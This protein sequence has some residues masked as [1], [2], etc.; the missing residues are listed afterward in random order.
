[1]DYTIAGVEGGV[2]APRGFRAAGVDAGLVPAAE[3][4][5][6]LVASQHTAAA[7]GRLTSHRFASAP[8]LWTRGCVQEGAARGIVVHAGVANAATGAAGLEDA[9]ALAGSVAGLLACQP[10]EVMVLGTGRIG[11]RLDLA[12]A[13]DG[14]ARAVAALS[15]RGS[16][17]AGRALLASGGVLCERAAAVAWSEGELRIGGVAK[18]SA[19]FAPSFATT[20]ALLTTDARVEAGLLG[21]ILTRAVRRSF[22]R[23][24]VDQGPGMGDAVVL[25]ANGTAAAPQLAPGAEGAVA[26]EAALGQLCEALAEGLAMRMPGSRKLLAVTVHGAATHG[27]ALTA[28]RAVANSI[29][30]RIALAGSVAAWP[31]VLDALGACSAPFD[32]NHVSVRFGPVTVVALG[33]LAPHDEGA[34][35]AVAAKAQVDIAI[36]LGAGASAATVTTTDLP[37]LAT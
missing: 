2:C 29:A 3:P 26:F 31:A 12:A 27:D 8:V 5:F 7:A 11:A 32:P 20:L 10:R 19:P 17:D 21:E 36:D 15:R 9:E 22:E 18:A 1:M 28:A 6:A 23:V 37:M 13:T 25:L 35:A 4:D 33:R 30:L 24:L 16:S 14:A 34:A